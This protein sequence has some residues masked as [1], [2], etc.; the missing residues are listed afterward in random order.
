MKKDITIGG[1]TFRCDNDVEVARAKT[2]FTKEEGTVRWLQSELRPG[3]VFYDVGANIGLYTVLAGSLVGPTGRVYAFEPHVANA[4]HLLRNVA[5]N[6]LNERVT[7]ITAALNNSVGWLDFNYTS[8]LPGSSGSQLGHTRAES[9][10]TFVPKCTELK[11]ATTIDRL[12]ADR[13]IQFPDVIKIDVD[14]NELAVL[15]GITGSA[16]TMLV[17]GH[18]CS[19]RSIQV[20]VHPQDMEA[21]ANHMIGRGYRLAE[22]HWTAIGKRRIAKGEPAKTIVH[23]AI[24][25]RVSTNGQQD[26][27]RQAGQEA[28]ADRSQG[29]A[30]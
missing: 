8:A 21:I 17:F 19:P 24:Y 1:F 11:W 7:V 6:N 9:G 25:R 27:C 23:N 18:G 20:E 28:G 10:E 3:D 16:Q 2:M 29:Q 26:S 14:G 4:A 15:K 30:R 12:L 5:A 13:S 22:R